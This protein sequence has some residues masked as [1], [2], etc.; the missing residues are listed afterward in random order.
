MLRARKP[1]GGLL[2]GQ[3]Q[4]PPSGGTK[5]QPCSFNSSRAC[6][7]GAA[8]PRLLGGAQEKKVET[9]GTTRVPSPTSMDRKLFQHK[10]PSEVP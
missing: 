4:R 1:G 2:C 3:A 6:W 10:L 7:L 5:G 9:M 8:L